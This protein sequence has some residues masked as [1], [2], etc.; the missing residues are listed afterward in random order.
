MPLVSRGL[1]ESGGVALSITRSD[2]IYSGWSGC[3]SADQDAY[4]YKHALNGI[5]IDGLTAH[6]FVSQERRC[7]V[8]AFSPCMESASPFFRI[9]L[10]QVCDRGIRHD[11]L[12]LGE[13]FTQSRNGQIVVHFS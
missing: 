4:V 11:R 1:G 10:L 12:L 7:A 8:V 3:Q 2:E 13:L 5:R 6:G 9:G